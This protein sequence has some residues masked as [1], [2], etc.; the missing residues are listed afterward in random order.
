MRTKRPLSRQLAAASLHTCSPAGGRRSAYVLHRR[1]RGWE[2]RSGSA[3]QRRQAAGGWGRRAL[4]FTDTQI[5]ADTRQLRRRLLPCLAL[6]P[7]S[8]SRGACVR[9]SLLLQAG[10]RCPT[11]DCAPQ[12]LRLLLGASYESLQPC[13][14]RRNRTRQREPSLCTSSAC[15]SSVGSAA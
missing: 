12:R 4:L 5:F 2:S 13:A 6:R 14:A 10:H 8:G 1:Y 9:A 15:G 3:G 7:C 11:R